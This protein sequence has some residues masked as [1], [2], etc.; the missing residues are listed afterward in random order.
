M[1]AVFRTQHKYG[2]DTATL[3]PAE[4]HARH[5]LLHLDDVGVIGY[6][7]RAGY[8]DPHLTTHSYVQRA[9]DLGV[10]VH[11]STPVIRLELGAGHPRVH[12]PTGVIEAGQVVLAAG[13]WTN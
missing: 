11:T 3:A 2:I 9:R 12:T 6:D 8:C 7:S 1:Q 5:P 13:P 10:T 4:A